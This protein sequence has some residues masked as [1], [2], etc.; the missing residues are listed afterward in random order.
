MSIQGSR[1]GTGAGKG[2]TMHILMV[3]VYRDKGSTGKLV[4]SLSAYMKARGHRVT[5][6]FRD[7]AADEAAGYFRIGRRLETAITY[8]ANYLFGTPYGGAYLSTRRLIRIIKKNQI[9]AVCL[10][11]INGSYI[12][13]YWLLRRLKKEGIPVVLTHHSEYLYTGNCTHA[14]ACEKWISG[15]HHCDEIR[16]QHLSRFLDTTARSYAKMRKAFAGLENCRAVAVSDWVL[17]R[18]RQSD[19]MKDIPMVTI[20]NGVD[21]EIYYPRDT[22]ERK[23]ELGVQDQ[24]TVLFCTA[25]FSDQENDNKGG[26]FILELADRLKQDHVQVL[27][28]ALSA[29][30]RGEHEN[31]RILGAVT[32]EN[33]LAEL[34]AM[35]DVLV[36]TSKRETFSMPLAEALMCGTPVAGFY[37]GGPEAIAIR[38]YTRFCPYGDV[39][40]LYSHVRELIACRYDP[41]VIA[42][43]AREKYSVETMCEKYLKLVEEVTQGG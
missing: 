13:I 17:D 14:M 20:E 39:D 9:D 23:T 33:R 7:G 8:R 21:P 3:N 38:E 2:I 36:I 6:C 35:A 31:I 16:Q 10:H 19:I 26:R 43:R 41:Q 34:Y 25:A 22:Q 42:Q 30:I 18:A 27:V 4:A 37:A 11:S 1:C 32:D 24:P 29:D 5:H 40:A 28:A 15:C 12:N